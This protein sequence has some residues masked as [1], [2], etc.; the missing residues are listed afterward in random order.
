[1]AKAKAP[2]RAKIEEVAEPTPTRS[3]R[4]AIVGRPNV[5]K[6]T[7]LNAALEL[8][9]AIVSPTPQTT[10]DA[11]L[12][13]IHRGPV[14]IGLLDTPGLHRAETELGRRMNRTA[15]DVALSADVVVFVTDVPEEAKIRGRAKPGAELRPNRMLTPHAGDVTLLADIGKGAP[16][17][18]VVNKL[19]RLRD[20]RLVLPL[21]ESL[22][23][24]RDFE[25]IV[26]ISALRADGIERVLDEVGKLCPLGPHRYGEDDI[27]DRPTRFFASEYVREQVLLATHEEVPHATAVVVDDF[28]EPSEG[29]IT[30]ITAT[31]HVERPGQKRILVGAGGEMM[32]RIGT[33]ARQRIEALWG[34]QVHLELWVRVTPRW[35]ER[36]EQLDE[37]G[38]G[39]DRGEGKSGS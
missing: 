34:H 29:G 16:V 24:L 10:R 7:L 35:R 36:A 21:L 30:R 9:L 33:R 15:R 2:K 12:G 6:S 31:I 5:G 37:L 39:R 23:Q 25:A 19:D 8:P 32:K 1:V 18:L 17:V 3:G 38:Y 28:V 20:K 26:P 14:E 27:T 22:G 13:V 11:L 4:V